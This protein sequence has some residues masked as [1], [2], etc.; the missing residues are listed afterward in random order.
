LICVSRNTIDG[1]ESTLL[2]K[3]K[4]IKKRVDIK[5]EENKGLVTLIIFITVMN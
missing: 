1:L 4:S 3:N 2:A 5:I